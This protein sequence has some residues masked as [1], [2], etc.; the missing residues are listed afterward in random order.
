[1]D[2]F[3]PLRLVVVGREHLSRPLE[4]SV[5]LIGRELDNDLVLDSPTVSRH[6]A[7]LF[8]AADGWRVQDLQSRNGVAVRGVKA[9]E[10]PLELGDEIKIGD[11]VLRVEPIPGSAEDDDDQTMAMA[12]VPFVAQTTCATCGNRMGVPNLI[13]EVIRQNPN[14]VDL[15]QRLAEALRREFGAEGVFLFSVRDTE[16]RSEPKVETACRYETSSEEEGLTV[17]SRS[18]L[19]EALKE[20]SPVWA[21]MDLMKPGQSLKGLSGAQILIYPFLIGGRVSALLYLDWGKPC[22]DPI[23]PMTVLGSWPTW[24]TVLLEALWDLRAA[25]ARADQE[26]R[27][28]GALSQAFRRHIDPGE[29]IGSSSALQ[30]ALNRASAAAPSPYPI[31]LLGETGVGKEVF[32]RWVHLHSARSDGPFIALNCAG[33]PAGTAESELFGHRRGAFTGADRDHAG[34]FEQAEGGTLF[35]DEIGDMDLHAPG[36]GPCARSSSASSAG[37]GTTGSGPWTSA[38]SRPRTRTCDRPSRQGFREDLYYRLTTFELHL[39]PLRQRPSDIPILA[40]T[41]LARAFKKAGTATGFTPGAL[42][43]LKECG[44]PGNVRQLESAVNHLSASA[45]GP[46][47]EEADV[48][49]LLASACRPGGASSEDVLSAPSRGRWRC[50]RRPT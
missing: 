20:K 23:P 26:A 19:R 27:H 32:A 34:V 4:K 10:A 42:A 9:P 48:R 41:F 28:G 44:W 8:L 15:D 30:E 31:L 37:W 17:L 5:C 49:R 14:P 24:A 29:I 12:S 35:L 3:P 47:I 21:P 46:L 16:G 18:T 1:M 11:T 2:R 50:S 13:E 40:T 38:S 25:S 45:S 22:Q 6:H 36:Q 43:A 39:P 7:R 33:I